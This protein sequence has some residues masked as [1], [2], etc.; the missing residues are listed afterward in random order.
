MYK[1]RSIP[2]KDLEVIRLD[3]SELEAVRLCDLE[4]LDQEQAGER[5]RVSRGTVFRLLKSGRA[6]LAEAVAG[7]KALIIEKGANDEDLLP[8]GQ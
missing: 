7:S 3:L 2:M 6:K 8:N 1:P 4:R 5:M